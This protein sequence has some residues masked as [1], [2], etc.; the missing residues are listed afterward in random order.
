MVSRCAVIGLAM[1]LLFTCPARAQDTAFD[2]LVK[3]ITTATADFSGATSDPTTTIVLLNTFAAEVTTFPLGSSSGGFAW[4]FDPALGVQT[5]RSNS[6]GP[7]FAQR[8]LTNG[9]GK[10]TV[11]VAFQH[12]RFSSIAGQPLDN[13]VSAYPVNS[14]TTGV[15]VGT[16]TAESNIEL[17]TDRTTISASYG[18]TDRLDVGIVVPIGR[19]RVAGT[20]QVRGLDLQNV[21]IIPT[22]VTASVDTSSSGVG[23]VIFRGKFELPMP[24]SFNLAAGVDLRVH[25]GD[26]QKLLGTGSNAATIL[27][28]GATTRGSVSPHFNVGYTFAG[29]GGFFDTTDEIDYILGADIAATSMVTVAGDV[30]GRSLR[31]AAS[32]SYGAQPSFVGFASQPGTLHL[33]LG[34]VGVKVRVAGMWLATASVLFPLSDAGVKPGVTP[35]VGFERAF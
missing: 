9:R 20:S 17:S 31:D 26:A 10:L 29:T 14:S 33:L 2:G 11:A 1:L 18:I 28:M 35:V 25:T 22:Q 5:R 30:I 34:T 27:V 19:T 23:D 21:E 8:P 4:S 32:V 24:K 13:L 12:T 6:F 16:V 3:L 7:M 15:R